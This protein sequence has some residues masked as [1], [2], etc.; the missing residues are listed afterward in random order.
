MLG[1]PEQVGGKPHHAYL[2]ILMASLTLS[3]AS[4]IVEAA[5]KEARSLSLAPM[6]VVVLDAGG[7]AVALKRED[8]SGIL[9]VEIAG[10]KAWGALG[11]GAGS[12]MLADR[13]GSGALGAA[14]VGAA[15]AASGGRLIPV[16]GGVLVQDGTG[17]TIGAVGVSGDLSDKDEACA[18]A[19]I[20]AAGLASHTGAA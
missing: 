8:G 9:R 2:E 17:A 5:L 20:E 15:A 11:V 7:H 4:T 3:Q 13:V 12:R 14:F 18:V 1:A 16:A 6:T 19:G 10:G